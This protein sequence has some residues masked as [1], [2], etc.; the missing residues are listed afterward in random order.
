MANGRKRDRPLAA[1]S[2]RC[3]NCFAILLS[4]LTT[5]AVSLQ[6]QAVSTT[7]RVVGKTCPSR[8]P[9]PVGR[10]LNRDRGLR[11]PS[12][13]SPRHRACRPGINPILQTSQTPV[14]APYMTC[15]RPEIALSVHIAWLRPIS[16]FCHRVPL[17][18]SIGFVPGTLGRLKRPQQ[19]NRLSLPELRRLA[20][21]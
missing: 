12:F 16:I 4:A 18:S 15:C 20:L 7:A 14:H 1:L 21:R 2:K 17:P 19:L 11:T 5:V 10:C 3:L 6:L 13:R 9:V 8:V